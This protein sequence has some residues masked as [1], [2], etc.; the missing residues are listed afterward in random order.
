VGEGAAGFDIQLVCS[1]SEFV[2]TV[3]HVRV[4]SWVLLGALH[5]TGTP[6]N[7]PSIPIDASQQIADQIQ[8]VLAG[9]AEQSKVGHM[10]GLSSHSPL[11]VMLGPIN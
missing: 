1:P 4:L 8:F 2:D 3:A 5:A 9:F 6:P 7:M 11:P 10:S